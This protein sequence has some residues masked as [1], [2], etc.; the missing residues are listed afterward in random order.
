MELQKRNGSFI[1][2]P[3]PYFTRIQQGLV[4]PICE[5]PKKDWTR[6]KDW[7]CCSGECTDKLT[8]EIIYGWPELRL[9]V[10]KRDNFSCVKCGAVSKKE[11]VIHPSNKEWYHKRYII[12]EIIKEDEIA[13]RC[14]LGE[15]SGLI[16]DHIKPIAL[17]GVE[18]D[19]DNCQTLCIVCNKI[20]TGQDIAQ[21]NRVRK[22]NP[23]QT[24]L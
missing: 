19:I 21:I 20:K 24:L 15:P 10:F 3:D 14:F 6:R 17:G 9:K 13:V 16:A 18:S 23:E 4:C 5:K 11:Q 7:R 8:Q 1:I 12:F 2:I 22:L